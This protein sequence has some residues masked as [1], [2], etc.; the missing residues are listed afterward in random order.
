[1]TYFKNNKNNKI[2][3]SSLSFNR[4]ED[5]VRIHT[6]TSPLITLIE[7]ST[8]II[9]MCDSRIARRNREERYKI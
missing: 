6:T 4:I 2:K 8:G 7:V 3:L 9:N 1:M 5:L